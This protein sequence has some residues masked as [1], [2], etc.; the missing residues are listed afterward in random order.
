MI[1]CLE[2]LFL[3]LHKENVRYVVFKGVNHLSHDLHTAKN[4]IDLL[5]DE[6]HLQKA[7]EVLAACGFVRAK[8]SDRHNYVFLTYDIS[9]HKQVMVHVCTKVTCGDKP[10]KPYTLPLSTFQ[11]ILDGVFIYYNHVP[12]RVLPRSDEVLLA[13]MIRL[14]KCVNTK[15]NI[16]FI[17][18]NIQRCEYNSANYIHRVFH[19]FFCKGS[20]FREV[21][22]Y[23]YQHEWYVV[24]LCFFK[25]LRGF[26]YIN[27]FC[28]F[29][30]MSKIYY[31]SK[32][33]QKLLQLPN[34]RVHK[35]L[36]VVLVGVDG[37]GKSSCVQQL[38][39]NNFLKNTGIKSIYFGNKDYWLPGVS[40][41]LKS[42][43]PFLR[44]C[45]NLLSK[46]D[47]QL[48]EVAVCWWLF[49]GYTVV[50]DRYFYDDVIGYE[51]NRYRYSFLKK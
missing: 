51:L 45:G 48:R 33:V 50:G 9:V 35:G 5:V 15:Q 49:R 39:Q 42:D 43:F 32:A 1:K 4:D 38:V 6:V 46:V 11:I 3:Y 2:S 27:Y 26:L 25:K 28:L 40:V 20:S 7:F 37:S 21:C 47:R 29:S 8:S 19:L 14:C 36:F 24:R 22:N 13:F 41:L 31:I 18:S 10:M 44:L 16:Y 23:I 34:Y 12:I 17:Q 30:Q